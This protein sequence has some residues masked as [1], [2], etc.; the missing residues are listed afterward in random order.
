MVVL[1]ARVWR[2]SGLSA[3]KRLFAFSI[4]YLFALFAVLLA[5]DLL[6]H[7]FGRAV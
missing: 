2:E 3:A 5:D 1:A 4:L 7:L 6:G